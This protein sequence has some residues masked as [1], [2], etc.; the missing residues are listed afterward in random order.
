[1]ENT[2]SMEAFLPQITMV[3]PS[4][5]KVTTLTLRTRL[6]VVQRAMANQDIAVSA[7][8]AVVALVIAAVHRIPIGKVAGDIG[9]EVANIAASLGILLEQLW[10]AQDWDTPHTSIQSGRIVRANP[11][12]VSVHRCISNC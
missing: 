9:A 12:S 3:G 5:S 11:V 1:M 6:L 8:A 10:P 7:A 4:V 2:R